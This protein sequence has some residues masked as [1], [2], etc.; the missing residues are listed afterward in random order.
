LQAGG[1][2][3]CETVVLWLGTAHD[4]VAE[5][6]EAYR[7]EQT[8]EF[9]Y[10]HIP[11]A[12]MRAVMARIRETR[13]QILAQ[14][15][16]HPEDAFHSKA[17]DT[18]AIVRHVGAVSIVIPNFARNTAGETFGEHSATYRLDDDDRWKRT[19]FI[20]VVEVL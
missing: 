11:P 6:R 2:L 20:D 14:V 10:F 19:S 3:N 1:K 5:V 8:V 16:S 4:G 17:D 15:H 13:F 12:S 7:P 9:D 18:W